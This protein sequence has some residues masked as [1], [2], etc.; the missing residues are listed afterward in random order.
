MFRMSAVD[1]PYILVADEDAAVDECPLKISM[2]MPMG[3][4]LCQKSVKCNIYKCDT[5][6]Y[7]CEDKC[8]IAYINVMSHF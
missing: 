2:L 4:H 7:I 8:G 6:I 3:R 5:Y 1:T